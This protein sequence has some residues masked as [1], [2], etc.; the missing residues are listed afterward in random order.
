MK[1]LKNYKYFKEDFEIEETDE[2][3]VKIS[4]E[5]LNKLK[6]QISE[7]NS[8]KSKIDTLYKSDNQ[9]IQSELEKIL[10]DEEDRNPFLLAYSNISSMKKKI[11]DL[12]I[13]M[14]EKAIELSDFKDKLSIAEDNESRTEL[15][16]K[17]N[18]IHQQMTD[19]K[20]EL[21]DS[22]KKVPEMEEELKDKIE[23][24]EEDMKKWIEKIQ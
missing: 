24:R 3:D 12:H 7:F 2:E 23:K 15:T 11:E 8:K 5:E 20:K 22:I 1:Y 19:M 14:N 4:K 13:R 9:D 16:S 21:D 17:I 10:G 18:E 6:D